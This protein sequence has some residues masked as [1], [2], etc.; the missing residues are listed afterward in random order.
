MCIGF[1]IFCA[2][3][4]AMDNLFSDND[5]FSSGSFLSRELSVVSKVISVEKDD[6]ALSNY[7]ELEGG[8]IIEGCQKDF[9]M[10]LSRGDEVKL[11]GKACSFCVGN[12]RVIII[13]GEL[14]LLSD[15]MQVLN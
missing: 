9:V 3:E 4:K 2:N 8:W 6:N 13:E 12:I 1:K 11:W 15:A 5:I 14:A 7:I 10:K